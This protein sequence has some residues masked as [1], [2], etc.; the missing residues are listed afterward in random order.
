MDLQSLPKRV[1]KTQL[2][3]TAGYLK[4]TPKKLD[5]VSQKGRRPPRRGLECPPGFWLSFQTLGDE[6]VA[7]AIVRRHGPPKGPYSC[8]LEYI[9]ARPKKGKAWP[10]VV[11]AIEICRSQ[12]CCFL[13]SAAD[14]SQTGQAWD[15]Q[16]KSACA[17]HD[18]WGFTEVG[19]KE[20]RGRGLTRYHTGCEVLLTKKPVGPL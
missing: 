1:E 6:L 12:G 17:V 5:V 9:A 19:S 7:A 14:L 11:A 4:L 15:N 13:Y 20:W 2:I 16:A 18:T 8:T 10:L 3:M